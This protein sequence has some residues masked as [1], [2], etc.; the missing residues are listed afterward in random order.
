[1]RGL[2]NSIERAVTLTDNEEIYAHDLPHYLQ[3]LESD[4]MEG[5]GFPTLEEMVRR[6]VMKVL[7][8][9]GYNKGITAQIL[10]IPRTTLWR[11]LKAYGVE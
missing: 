2:E 7:E 8:K 4:T 1:M 10:D 9:T 6:Y 3:Q 11:K 5:E